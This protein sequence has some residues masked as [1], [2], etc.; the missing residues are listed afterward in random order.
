MTKPLQPVI[1]PYGS[2]QQKNYTH[3][4]DDQHYA[5][6]YR[7]EAYLLLMRGRSALVGHG[8]MVKVK[9]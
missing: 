8:C 5:G 4:G 6:Q 2:V 3:N 7:Y 1:A 9:V